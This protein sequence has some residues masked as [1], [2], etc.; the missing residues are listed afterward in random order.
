MRKFI[1]L[2]VCVIMVTGCTDADISALKSYGDEHR[3]KMYSGGVLVEEWVPT[4][5][6]QTEENSDGYVFRSKETGLFIRVSGDVV[7]EST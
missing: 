7:V 3:I 6:V 4:G 1:M 2:F 5:K